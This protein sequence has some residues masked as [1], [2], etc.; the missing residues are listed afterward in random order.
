M[1]RLFD[2]NKPLN[3]VSSLLHIHK[4]RRFQFQNEMADLPTLSYTTTNEIAYP[5]ITL[6][7]A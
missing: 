1:Q 3:Q 6:S 5:F 4:M 7:Y 2:M